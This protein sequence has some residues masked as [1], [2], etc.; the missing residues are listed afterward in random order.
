MNKI[1]AYT[2]TVAN[3]GQLMINSNQKPSCGI[4]KGISNVYIS[5]HNQRSYVKREIIKSR[6]TIF[7]VI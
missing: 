5:C 3:R 1:E 7:Q 2:R 4:C 6:V